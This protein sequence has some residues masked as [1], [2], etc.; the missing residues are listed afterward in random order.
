ME[1]IRK[2]EIS[3]Y[4]KRFPL[5]VRFYH[6]NFLDE[7]YNKHVKDVIESVTGTGG[8]PLIDANV[9]REEWEKISKRIVEVVRKAFIKLSEK[10][11]GLTLTDIKNYWQ[12]NSSDISNRYLLLFIENKFEHD[13]VTDEII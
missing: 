9:Y 11:K 10:E 4:E 2:E 8:N 13:K 3:V 1:R 5:S 6:I 12:N 7:S